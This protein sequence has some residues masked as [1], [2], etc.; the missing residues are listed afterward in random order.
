[1]STSK[2]DP[3]LALIDFVKPNGVH[4]KVNSFPAS[5]EAAV[6][7]GWLPKKEFEAAAKAKAAP[8]PKKAPAGKK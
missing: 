2:E 1:M 4:L 7:K 8:A 5:L 3:R 6:A